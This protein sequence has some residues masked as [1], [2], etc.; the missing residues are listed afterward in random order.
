[1]IP[2]D[3]STISV[4]V[5]GVPLN[6]D[7]A[8]NVYRE[9][10]A[11]LL[12]GYNNSQGAMLTFLLDTTLYAN[13]VHTLAL[14]VTDDAGNSAGIGSRFFRVV[15]VE[16][17]D[18]PASYTAAYAPGSIKTN[19]AS[20]DGTL[21][22]TPVLVRKGYDASTTPVP[23][24]PDETGTIRMGIKE[25]QRIEIS[26]NM[27]GQSVANGTVKG[28]PSSRYHGYLMEGDTAKS[29]PT[30][31]FL[32]RKNGVF[33]WQPGPGFSGTYPLVFFDDCGTFK[34]VTIVIR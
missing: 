28:T 30:G 11:G 15:N 12:P 22:P 18:L 10:V 14:S 6:G 2:V 27:P 8:Y 1:T 4:W 20:L 16:S 26:L 9:D 31:S 33:Y 7:V 29:L 17:S 25:S 32:D 19:R 24:S 21:S 13:G 23:L 3:G 34:K 5:D